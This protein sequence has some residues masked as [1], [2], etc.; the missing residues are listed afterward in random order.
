MDLAI[1]TLWLEF[2]DG[3]ERRWGLVQALASQPTF[4]SKRLKG[5]KYWY[6]QRYIAGKISQKYFSPANKET[7]AQ[8]AATRQ[9]R[10]QTLTMLRRHLK[11]EKR[12]TAVLHRAGL[13]RLD[14]ITTTVLT[15]LSEA[16]LI[17]RHGVLVGSHAF[18][19]Y[20]GLLGVLFASQTLRTLDID[21]AFDPHI[22]IASTPATQLQ[23][24]LADLDLG[25]T[26]VPGLSHKYPPHAFM[27][28]NGIRIDIIAPLRGRPK[29]SIRIPCLLDAAA[30]PLHF[31]D[32]L[33]KDPINT[34]LLGVQGGIPVTVP[35]PIR[36]ALHKLIVS[37]RRSMAE[38]AK[39][40]KDLLQAEQLLEVCAAEYPDELVR[41]YRHARKEGKQWK[42][43]LSGAIAQLSPNTQAIFSRID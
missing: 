30:E 19:A 26:A 31:L 34:V 8:I 7:D 12:R 6:T 32:F 17:Y 39:R 5:K 29:P 33:L 21:I 41:L 23:E 22:T 36:F 10:R 9:Q 14:R 16:Q 18:A 28:P 3:V 11:D 1:R 13:P 2:Q 25:F 24:L 37:S 4:V 38:A 35:H 20:S 40:Q 43:A 42:A 27:N 15:A